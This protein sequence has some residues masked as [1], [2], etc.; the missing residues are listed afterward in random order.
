MAVALSAGVLGGALLV[1]RFV[2]PVWRPRLYFVLGLPLGSELVPI[3]V[4]P[5]GDGHAA[6][7]HYEVRDAEV[8]FW[9]DAR[10]RRGAFGLHGMV[11]LTALRDGRVG[12]TVRW[13][14]PWVAMLAAV[15]LAALATL[16]G[17]PQIGGP[18]AAVLLLSV[19]IVY[20]Q[21]AVR[22]AEELRWAFTS[23]ED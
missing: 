5:E 9:A 13:S 21:A 10:R 8:L 11:Q 15:W 3:S 19:F 6:T 20:Q 18:I 14:P 12:L 23:R 17:E 7:V 1:E 22:A 2:V 16:R 4:A